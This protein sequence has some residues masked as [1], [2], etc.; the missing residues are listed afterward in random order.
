MPSKSHG[1]SR[2]GLYK[3]WSAMKARCLNP[4]DESYSR[5]GG[6]GIRVC[7]RWLKFENFLQ[8]MGIPEL[9]LSL[10]RID[11]DKGYSLDNCKWATRKEQQ[12]NTR[13]NRRVD[14]LTI[15]ELAERYGLSHSTAALR[16]KRGHALD[17]PIGQI[18]QWRTRLT[19]CIRGHLFSGY[20]LIIR[21]NG[22]RQC[23]ACLTI[24]KNKFRAKEREK[25][26]QVRS[27]TANKAVSR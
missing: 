12:N 24:R 7:E 26:L 17:I 21:R 18:G 14:G 19:H 9:G 23:R 5:Y 8:D 22:S 2:T 16:I 6:R 13:R 11:N 1:W 10:E 4:K 27:S 15:T 3:R 25:C 20:N